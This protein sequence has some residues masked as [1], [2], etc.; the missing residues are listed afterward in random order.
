MN[1]SN[2]ELDKQYK[3]LLLLAKRGD[4][5]IFL[6]L[7]DQI[8]SL[9]KK[10][11]NINYH[12]EKGNTALHY[13][14]NEGNL[15]I[16]E[17]LLNNNC[18]PNLENNDKETPL[19]LASKNGYFDISKK[20]I[21]KGALLNIYNL[22]KNSPI[23]YICM[24]N[25]IELLK[26]CLTKFPKVDSENIYG[27]KPIDLTDD[28]EIK[29]LLENYLKNKEEKENEENKEKKQ[30]K[31]EDNNKKRKKEIQNS[32]KKID[33]SNLDQNKNICKIKDFEEICLSP[34]IKT[35]RRKESNNYEFNKFSDFS[36]I[37]YTN[38]D[39]LPSTTSIDN[40]DPINRTIDD[41]NTQNKKIKLFKTNKNINRIIGKIKN[42]E[43]ENI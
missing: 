22:D 13:A 18:N 23:H 30:K 6:D 16:V 24:N 34:I 31:K 26:Y 32:K 1:N 3:K 9:P 27:K 12:D 15:K 28:K 40:Y 8:I 10:S 2:S 41:K 38:R 4:T 36:R 5:Q 7:F 20:L 17:K 14:C 21:E 33:K 37:N 29:E 35:E 42:L 39:S 43:K 11:L 19:H 25:C